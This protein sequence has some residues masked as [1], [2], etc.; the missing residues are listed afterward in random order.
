MTPI[1]ILKSIGYP[2][3][4]VV[5]DFELYFDE[6]IC[7]GDKKMT[8][9]EYL[10]A[11][12]PLGLA[13]A[14]EDD[15]KWYGEAGHIVESA[16]ESYATGYTIIAANASF[17]LAVAKEF[18]GVEF[19]HTIDICSLA[20][21]LN[22]PSA[23]IEN[24]AKWLVPGKAKG[25]TMDFSGQ[26]YV[27]EE[28]IE[29]AMNDADIEWDLF[30]KLLPLCPNPE[31]EIPAQNWTTL[32]SLTQS[33]TLSPDAKTWLKDTYAELA[34]TVK[35]VFPDS[36][37]AEAATLLRKNDVIIEAFKDLLP[38]GCPMKMG[39][40]CL[41]PALS[42]DDPEYYQLLA[43]E[44]PEVVNLV[45]ARSKAKCTPLHSGRVK[46]LLTLCKLM[47]GAFGAPLIYALA[48]TGRWAGCEKVNMQNLPPWIKKLVV[49]AP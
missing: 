30:H 2:T 6:K 35:H 40:K 1:E 44:N 27:S 49:P 15:T 28:L 37:P 32:T 18:Y 23:S 39:A 34:E 45:K 29:Y 41:I 22:F 8:L 5:L 25:N 42:K 11:S 14:T 31:I 10:N 48:V 46:R 16:L 38:D 17:D 19:E 36:T 43:H 33:F 13:V 21:I 20:R 4:Y 24:L 9:M 12:Y 26:D 47:G 7:L 3:K